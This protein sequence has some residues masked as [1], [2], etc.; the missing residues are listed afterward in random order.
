MI[1]ISRAASTAAMPIAPATSAPDLGDDHGHEHRDQYG[2]E[3]LQ[4]VAVPEGL[5]LGAAGLGD[6]GLLAS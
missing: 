1:L 4:A 6:E 3:D 2:A 5:G